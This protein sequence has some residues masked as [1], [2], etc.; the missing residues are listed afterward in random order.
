MS[1]SKRKKAIQKVV[2]LLNLATSTNSS[3]SVMALRHAESL[4]RQYQVAQRELPILQLCDRSMLYRVS[5]GGAAPRHQ[6]ESTVKSPSEGSVYQ[7]RF[8]EKIVM[9]AGRMNRLAL[10]WTI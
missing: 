3:E 10:F 9:L 8:S 4:I 6:K 1:I 7:R 5:W 2:K